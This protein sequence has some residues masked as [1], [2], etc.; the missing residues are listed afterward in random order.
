MT[1]KPHS[2]QYLGAARDYWW[3]EDF[4]ELIAKR[5]DLDKVSS[6]LDVG[7]GVGHWGQLLSD[8]LPEHAHISGIDREKTWIHKAQERT[9]GCEKRFDYQ[10][11]VGEKI[12]FPDAS[13]DMV[14]CQTLL[15]HVKDV[16]VA[17]KEM[18]RVLKPGGLLA[19]VESNNC[20]SQLIFDSLS[21][22]DSLEDR[23]N[24]IRFHLTCERGKANLGGGFES[25]GDLIPMHFQQLGVTDIRVYL[26]DKTSAMIPPYADA[27]QQAYIEELKSWYESKYIVW[28]KED[29]LKYFLAGGG[30][31]GEFDGLWTALKTSFKNIL[32][33]IAD[34]TYHCSGG[35]IFYLISGRK[36]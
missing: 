25:V 9:K 21:S 2:A 14:T 20:A 22:Q 7:C 31:P 15:I 5:W 34:K 28:N 29:T 16:Q 26:S 33:A 18:L 3:N 36:K 27:E 4:L 12:P 1:K 23:L 10:V 13:F 6:L 32:D 11:G 24:A 35:N 17:L 30:K 8:F 19:V